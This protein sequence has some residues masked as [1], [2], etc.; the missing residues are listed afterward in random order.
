MKAAATSS[1][2]LA[3]REFLL[4]Q[5]F[6]G[7]FSREAEREALALLSQ[8]GVPSAWHTL[9]QIYE[10]R[11]WHAEAREAYDQA[12]AVSPHWA[13]LQLSRAALATTPA[14][15]EQALPA[16]GAVLPG[17]SSPTPLILAG[18]VLVTLVGA[19]AAGG[20]LKQK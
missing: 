20:L 7:A 1:E 9:G 13:D 19:G 3:A 11:G 8:Q 16:S 4:E 14:E 18:L 17:H 10:G 5:I 12:L 6:E 15:E 2:A